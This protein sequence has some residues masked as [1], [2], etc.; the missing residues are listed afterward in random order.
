MP[1][2]PQNQR[3]MSGVND[4]GFLFISWTRFVFYL[5]FIAGTI[6]ALVRFIFISILAIYQRRKTK[7][8]SYDSSFTPFVNV[9]I[10]AHNEEKLIVKTVRSALNSSYPHFRVTVVDDGSCD[11]TYD[12]IAHAFK[13]NPKVFLLT[14]E[15]TGKAG[16]LN[17]ALQK[18]DA[19]III[20]QDADTLMMPDAIEK[21]VRHFVNPT[22]AAVAGN[23]KVGNRV[24]FLTKCQALEYITS[25][26]LDRR[27]FD[28][29]N[30]VMV[31]P[32]A[33]GAWRAELVK[34]AGGFSD[35]TLAEDADL[36]LHLLKKGYT[37]HYEEDAIGLT[38]A[39]DTVHGFFRQR[40]RW[41][42]GTLQ[43]VWKNRDVMLNRR[44]GILG[45][46]A[47]PNVFIFQILFPFLA[48]FADLVAF[49]TIG[50]ALWQ[51]HQHPLGYSPD[52]VIHILF[53]YAL[54]LF[55]EALA[56]VLAFLLESKEDKRLLTWLFIQRFFYRQLMYVIAVRSVLTALQGPIVGWHSV[57]RKATVEER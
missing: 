26:N 49:T 36:T 18:V 24:N 33:I 5:L 8:I 48:P 12:V 7:Q 55:V 29:L 51:E 15:N 21:L 23:A 50:V 22:V 6:L 17:L 42:Y 9:I 57:E 16:A 32:G 39:P 46:L 54:F 10:P 28:V 1:A 40:F 52:T 3:V 19:D 27:A 2:A 37:V 30:C 44:Y 56:S 43:V 25:Q 41:M 31:V 53:Y 47:L 34:S 4:V 35:D 45:M 20:F 14:K 13:D 38:E 11:Q